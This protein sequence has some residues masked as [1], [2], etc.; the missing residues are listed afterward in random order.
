LT[1]SDEPKARPNVV[2]GV[3]RLP[4][5]APTFAGA[6]MRVRLLDV[7]RADAPSRTVAELTV[8]DVSHSGSPA[9]I[10]FVLPA[11]GVDPSAHYIVHVHIDVDVDGDQRV[12][13]GDLITT[14]SH[15]VLTFG[16][17][18]RLTVRVRA[19]GS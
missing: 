6:T 3:I 17:P 7:T 15:P 11:E 5:G 4:D 16:H 9:G 12:S 10:P 13:A 18:S 2:E 1:P 14:E 19:V 8:P